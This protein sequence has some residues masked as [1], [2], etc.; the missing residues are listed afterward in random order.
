MHAIATQVKG[1]RFYMLIEQKRYLYPL[2]LILSCSCAGIIG[3]IVLFYSVGKRYDF[4]EATLLEW[5][6]CNLVPILLL[7]SILSRKL[8]F[9]KI[10]QPN[11]TRHPAVGITIMGGV[12][13]VGL[14]FCWQQLGYVR[15]SA[16]NSGVTGMMYLILIGYSA[17]LAM[18]PIL[19]QSLR[20][21]VKH[22]GTESNL[23]KSVVIVGTGAL[24]QD[25]SKKIDRLPA[26]G[27]RVIGFLTLDRKDVG[28]R[29]SGHPVL[30]TAESIGTTLGKNIVDMVVVA[31]EKGN[32]RHMDTIVQRCQL[33]GIDIG[34]VTNLD[35]PASPQTNMDQL[36][37]LKFWI[38]R[39][40]DQPPEKLFCKRCFDFVV[41]TVLICLCLPI[42]VMLPILI[43]RDSPGPI[44]FRQTRVG[45]N[46]R[47][48][49]MYKFRSMVVDAESQRNKLMH[50]NE[51]DGP[52]FKMTVDPRVTQLG[53][54]LRKT[55]LDELP[56]LFNVLKGDISLVG[57]R[58]PLFEEVRQYRPWEKKRL[59]VLQGITGYWQ[60]SGR[61]EIKFDE[62]MKLDLMYIDQWRFTLDVILLLKTI[63]AV[64]ARKGA[65]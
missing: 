3:L 35:L 6:V 56:Q 9:G 65:Q 62:W 26:C 63:P 5:L 21:L 58:P 60:V 14:F 39:G 64:L 54:F 61:N 16:G 52:A 48:F 51:M 30:D 24:A 34:F 27:M 8:W 46:G 37:N 15:P 11:E 29:L 28:R 32:L 19:K 41:S 44:L 10:K 20:C 49:F 40:V 1:I 43:R 57:P 31:P 36:E 13:A 50:L 45:K 4:S 12:L 33:E 53:A 22:S 59:S 42:W 18:L 38:I 25:L 17:S 47:P 55:S 23:I 7:I 2:Y